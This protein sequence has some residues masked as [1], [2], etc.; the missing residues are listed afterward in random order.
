VTQTLSLRLEDVDLALK[1]IE[2]GAYGKCDDCGGE[3]P[4]ERL[5]V[6]PAARLCFMCDG[7]K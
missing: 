7:A 3:I 1:K 6:F 5:E 4:E 2:N